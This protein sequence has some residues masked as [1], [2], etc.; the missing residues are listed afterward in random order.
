MKL[1]S[2]S[3]QTFNTRC[4]KDEKPEVYFIQAEYERLK[5]IH[6]NNKSNKF[7]VDK[8]LK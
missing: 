7:F 1:Y 8:S 6:W 4:K 5:K 3:K 2:P